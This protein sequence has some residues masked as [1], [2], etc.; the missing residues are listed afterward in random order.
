MS[1]AFKPN[2][3]FK[4]LLLK[5]TMAVLILFAGPALAQDLKITGKVLD[6]KGQT[7]PGASVIVKGKTTGAATDVNGAF[8][9]K[10]AKGDV[11]VVSY[12]GYK[13]TEQKISSSS[14]IEFVLELDNTK[15]D[16]VV[17]VGYGTMKKSDLTA[18]ISSV[19][20]ED[21]IKKA[22]TDVNST[23]QGKISGINVTRGN[24]VAG[25]SASIQ[26]RGISTFGSTEPL[27]IVDGF[28]SS[29]STIKP[30]DIESIEVL[31]DGAAAAIYGSRSANGVIIITTKKGKSGAVKVDFNSFVKI[32]KVDKKLELLD[33]EGYK[34]MNKM[35][36]DN[37]FTQNPD[38]PDKLSMPKFVTLNSDINTNWQDAV[39]RTGVLQNYDLRISGGMDN[40]QYS[41]SADYS[42]DKSIV[43]SNQFQEKGASMKLNF[44]KSIL[45]IDA[46]MVYKV[47]NENP[48]KF[49]LGEVYMLSPL[50]PIYD[51]KAPSG[52]GLTNKYDLPGNRNVIADDYFITNKNKNQEFKGNI[53]AALNITKWLQ[54]K[55][56]YQYSNNNFQS[57]RHNPAYTADIKAVNEY[58]YYS[59]NRS[60]YEKQVS[61]NYLSI[62]KT[63]NEDHSLNFV[64]G[65][66]YEK[67]NYGNAFTGVNGYTTEYSIS[68]GNITPK[69]KP[70]GFL[71]Q[72]FQTL[73]GAKGGTP[74]IDGTKY[75]YVRL[76]YFTRL[77][78]SYK[79]KYLIQATIRRDGSSKFSKDSR[80]G[81]FPSVAFG[82]RISEENF[83]NKGVV[84]NLKFRA[85]WGRLGNESALG[86]YDH[87]A[88]INTGNSLW[89][90]YVQGLGSNPWPGSIVES[91]QDRSLKWE[92]TEQ[93]NIG[94]DFGLL[95]NKIT[96]TI[97]VFDK[98][99]KDL[100]ITKK[101]APSG[102]LAD[103]VL[104]VGEFQN[105]GV[106]IE[107]NY[108]DQIGE[109]GYNLGLNLSTLKNKVTKLADKGQILYGDGLYYG[110][111]I[112]TQTREGQSASA[113]YLYQANG[114]FQS[115]QDVQNHIALKADG[116]PL[117]DANGKKILLQPDAQPGDIRF[118]DTNK[119]GKI[120]TDDKIYSGTPLPKVEINL[121]GS[122]NYS[123]F[124]FN[125]QIGSGWGHKVYNGNRFTY[126][127]MKVPT[128]M[129]RSVLNAWTPTNT[130]TS[131]PRAIYGDPNNNSRESTRFL[132]DGDF[133]RLRQIQL[134]YTLPKSL[135]KKINIDNFRIYMSGDNLYTWTKYDG[136][137]P[138]VGGSVLTNG[139]D[140]LIFPFTKSYIFGIQLTF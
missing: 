63:I 92:T 45:D 9:I 71:D 11:L 102:G 59:E 126:E 34:K 22:T 47:K 84:N 80:W 122:V 14:P 29:L 2:L 115:T 30:S 117:L 86:Y 53:S 69:Q 136:L 135:L 108:Q 97:N 107:V 55:S 101:L 120:D 39:Y 40:L 10:V 111:Y 19:K 91:L 139:V 50:V 65:M 42:K 98:T 66:S 100:L 27:Y 96:G 43:I 13:P 106:E 23:L 73:Y 131:V 116:T 113:F 133:I 20:S 87:Q 124:D 56:T 41:V 49:S 75:E 25:A 32:N 57:M 121:N 46:S 140:N 114:L 134:G 103:P 38:N 33:S 95:N 24:G 99:T 79:S 18:S 125:F 28:P 138:E 70:G 36:F 88:M 1:N 35:M 61:E 51:E 109:V 48:I 54:L 127:S 12:I 8:S 110:E 137:D 89:L 130:N 58:P 16:E 68:N 5:L 60:L 67:T 104:N 81:N 62:N 76:S 4:S 128:N 21:I 74:V 93:T 26:V 77:N 78:Y 118:K 129:L 112:P 15:I 123:G 37:Y 105:R 3:S 90:G 72:Y 94:F 119:D 17:V 82:W 31:K 52:F 7:I 85:S 83:F 6:E 132:K 44:K 64:A